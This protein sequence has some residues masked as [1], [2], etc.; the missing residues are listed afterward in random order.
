MKKTLL[1]VVAM[2]ATCSAVMAQNGIVEVPDAEGHGFM[3]TT[4]SPN[5]KYIAGADAMTQGDS[6]STAR[7]SRL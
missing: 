4:M 5:G 2:M 6:C 3:A 1:T 7:A